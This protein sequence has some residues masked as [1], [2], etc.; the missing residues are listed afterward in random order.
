M[1]PRAG[2][3]ALIREINEA[4]IL[5]VVRSSGPVTRAT[6][7]A[8]TG[9]SAATVTGVTGRLLQASLVMETD[10]VTG[11]GGRPA[12]MLELGQDVVV[13][14]GVRVSSTEV[15]AVLVD[16]RGRIVA[17]DRQSLSSCEPEVVASATATAVRKAQS[18]A[19]QATILGVGVAVS[20][21]VDQAGGSV[22]HSGSMNWKDV[23]FRSLLGEALDASVEIDSYVNAFTLGLLLFEKSLEGRNLLTFSVGTSLGASVV[24][25]GR[26]HRGLNGAAGGFAHSHVGGAR[27][28]ERLCHCGASDCLETRSSLWGIRSELERRGLGADGAG[29]ARD[30][31]VIKEAGYHLGMAMANVSKIF[32]P[33][34]IVLAV[35][36]EADFPQLAA[37]ALREFKAQY[38]HE[39]D[40]APEFES[41]TIMPATLAR[42]AACMILAKLFTASTSRLGKADAAPLIN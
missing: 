1:Q 8:R 12:R 22:K 10:T 15:L 26:I 23:P 21:V 40:P 27:E 24:V 28:P 13:A 3:K 41:T 39:N 17:K 14:A 37:G 6:I 5:D 18:M 16:L 34:Q 4:F 35:A 29:P 9:L 31:E 2:S 30:A 33:E 25:E 20:G 38:K 7:A 42:G 11:T 36:P 32:A 19:P